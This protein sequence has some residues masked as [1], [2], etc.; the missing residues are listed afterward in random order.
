MADAKITNRWNGY[1]L[2]SWIK[3][4]T[5]RM[6]LNENDFFESEVTGLQI[7]LVP[8]LQAVILNFRGKGKF[9]TIES[10]AD[11]FENGEILSPQNTNLPPFNSPVI[12][13]NN[14]A[15]VENYLESITGP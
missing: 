2:E 15:E 8:G 9:R 12:I 11:T 6:R 13:F 10:Y 7:C 14:G 4:K 3:D 5:V 1:C